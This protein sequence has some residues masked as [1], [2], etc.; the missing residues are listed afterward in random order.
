MFKIYANSFN[1][2]SIDSLNALSSNEGIDYKNFP[3]KTFVFDDTSVKSHEIIFSKN[4]GT[5]YGMLKDLII[6]KIQTTNGNA[7]QIRFVIYLMMRY[8][9]K[10]FLLKQQ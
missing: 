6:S 8:Y 2:R 10:D 5:L 4:F 9:D 7:N 1:K 3:Y